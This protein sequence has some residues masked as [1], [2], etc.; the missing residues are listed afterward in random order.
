MK[1]R[2]AID[3]HGNYYRSFKLYSACYVDTN[4]D[5]VFKTNARHKALN[6][7][8]QDDPA[9]L[10]PKRAAMKIFNSWCRSSQIN[11]VDVTF[12][13]QET[14]RGSASYQNMH[15]YCARRSALTPKNKVTMHHTNDTNAKE[16]FHA[17]KTTLFAFN[18]KRS[19]KKESE[20]I[21]N[22]PVAPPKSTC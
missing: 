20:L 10:L 21:A 15:T 8:R 5:P 3:R 13:I 1:P 14:T 2:S 7:S 16:I 4:S 22:Q 17:Y 6:K 11:D 9:L 18:K 19:Y 12:V